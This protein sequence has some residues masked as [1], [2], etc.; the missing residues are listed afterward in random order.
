MMDHHHYKKTRISLGLTQEE[1]AARLKINRETVRRYEQGRQEMPETY[2]L[3]LYALW[4][5]SRG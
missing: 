3:A 5:I 2:R 4:R 1:L